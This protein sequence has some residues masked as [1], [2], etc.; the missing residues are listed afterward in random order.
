I[1][2]YAQQTNNYEL[3]SV[4]KR[5]K[6]VYF[7]KIKQN[8][9]EAL[10]YLNESLEIAKEHKLQLQEAKALHQLGLSY[11]QNN[12]WENSLKRMLYADQLM[13]KIGY[14]NIYD[15][16]RHLYSLALVLSD[17]YNVENSNNYLNL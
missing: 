17:L 2:V 14:E 11:Y 7:F 8:F 6:G 5:V 10:T 1:E 4:A 12:D 9:S 13:Q 3:L 15:V 16:S